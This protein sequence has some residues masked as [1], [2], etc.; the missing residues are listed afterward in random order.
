VELADRSFRVA[1]LAPRPALTGS[2]DS[3]LLRPLEN[4]PIC[5]ET[6]VE[7]VNRSFRVGTRADSPSV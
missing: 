1:T 2:W 6:V 4:C 7:L 3:N 5:R